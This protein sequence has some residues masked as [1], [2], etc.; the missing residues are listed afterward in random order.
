MTFRDTP[1]P[2]PRE[3]VRSPTRYDR[4]PRRASS[5]D[6]FPEPPVAIPAYHPL[7]DGSQLTGIGCPPVEEIHDP[8]ASASLA[9]G[10]GGATPKRRIIRLGIGRAR[11]QQDE[12]GVPARRVPFPGQPMAVAPAFRDQRG[13]NRVPPG[14]GTS[15]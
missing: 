6:V 3:G 11:V 9:P 14:H 13:H 7:G 12:K 8:D 1:G 4:A 15:Q 10:E 2:G 5:A